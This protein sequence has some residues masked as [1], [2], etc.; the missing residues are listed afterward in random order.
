MRNATKSPLFGI[1]QRALKMAIIA[2]KFEVS[3]EEI[4]QKVE[5]NTLSRRKFINNAGKDVLLGSLS[6][7]ITEGATFP[8]NKV[9]LRTSASKNPPRIAIIG[10]G[11]AGLNALHTLKK[12]GF[13]A[14]IY[15][16]SGRTGGRILSVQNAM[17]EGTWAEFGAE[18]ID[19]NH[20]DMWTLAK[21]FNIELM[22]LG[23]DS[24]LALTKEVFLFE[25]QSRTLTQVITAFR[26]FADKMKTDADRLPDNLNHETKDPYVVALDQ[27]S[28]SE[29]LET[30]GAQ[31]WIK[32]FIETAYQS[33]YG[34]STH[35]QSS[36]NLLSLIST[37][38]EGGK[39]E[40]YGDSDERYKV[41]GGNQSI[42]EALAKKYT[43][44]IELH[45]SLE[46]ISAT[47][48]HYNLTFTGLK[49][50][51][52]ADFVIVAAPFSRFRNVDIRIDMPKIKWEVV[53]KLGFGTHTKF[54][55]GMSQHFWRKQG[56][57][58]FCYT[59][60][61][62]PN[63]WDN[64]QLQT[65]DNAAAGLSILVG[66]AAGI[67]LGEGTPEAQKDI[68]LPRWEKVFKGATKHYNGKIARMHWASYPF[69]LGSYVCYTT[70]QYTSISGAESLPIGNVFFAGE[71]CGREFSG[72]MNGAARSGRE[73]AEAI[74]AKNR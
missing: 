28:I 54:M 38:T 20:T 21:E 26:D 74:V 14:T 13:N 29:Y 6:G 27:L 18:F 36:I 73:V 33:E 1:F 63:G 19:S 43:A 57:Q 11:I 60:V 5:E 37:N 46:V 8:A 41:K 65:G 44:H 23:Q 3:S 48:S 64:A 62:I 7:L 56:F 59:D 25:E 66:G 49:E 53:N 67:A 16:A 32:Q 58:G 69:T 51:I 42:P 72:F 4:G 30:I 10:A 9:I 55:L 52:K 70:G 45:R 12:A 71:H 22:D 31:G 50:P 2:N 24:E 39:F 15:E 40:L 61:G 68:Y 17:G 34:L 47:S 35:I